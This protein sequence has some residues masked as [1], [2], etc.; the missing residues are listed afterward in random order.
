[1]NSNLARGA[2]YRFQPGRSGNPGGR[3]KKRVISDRY[4]E[5]AEVELS[6]AD[7]IKYGLPEGATYGYALAYRIFR[8]ALDGKADAAREIREAIEGKT[9]QRAEL[10]AGPVEIQVTYEQPVPPR[11]STVLEAPGGNGNLE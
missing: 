5:L 8:A 10:A 1:M 2:P 7:R 3:P 6:E 4:A 11:S 9:G